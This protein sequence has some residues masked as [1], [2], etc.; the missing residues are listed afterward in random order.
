MSRVLIAYWIDSITAWGSR[1]SGAVT[2]G[3]DLVSMRFSGP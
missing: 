1:L 3:L 2:Q